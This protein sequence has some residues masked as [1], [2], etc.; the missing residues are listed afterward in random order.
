MLQAPA[1]DDVQRVLAILLGNL[2]DD[3][4]LAGGVCAAD[5]GLGAGP[6]R[7]QRAVCADVDALAVAV[8][9]EVIIAPQWV[10]LYLQHIARLGI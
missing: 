1:H 10:H 6:G 9:D 5:N 8:L 2:L 4:V 3:R 7:A